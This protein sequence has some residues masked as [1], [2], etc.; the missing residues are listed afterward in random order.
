MVFV[1]TQPCI[2]TRDQSCVAVCPVD[3][4]YVGER[5]LYVHPDECIDCGACEA[6]C[7]VEAIVPEAS[8]PEEMQAFVA[9]NRDMFDGL[10]TDGAASFGP[11]GRDHPL[12]K[13]HPVASSP[14]GSG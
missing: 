6:E 1:I 5:M 10:E 14:P 7:P 8:V 2:D 4:I 3:C 9:I 13:R 12:V 11:F